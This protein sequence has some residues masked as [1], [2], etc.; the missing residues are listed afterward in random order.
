[1]PWVYFAISAACFA[2]AFRTHSLGLAA[3]TLLLALGFLLAGALSLVSARIQSRTQNTAAMIG[4]E[5]AAAIRRRAATPTI[6]EGVGSMPPTA[7][8]DPRDD[9]LR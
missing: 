5:Q 8:D 7:H 4:P 6:S 3:L 2:V 1:M 9:R